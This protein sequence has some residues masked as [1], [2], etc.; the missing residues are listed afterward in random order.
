MAVLRNLF[1]LLL[2][3]AAWAHR[4][5]QQDLEPALVADDE[6]AA[7]GGDSCGMKMLQARASKDV[8]AR[9]PDADNSTS[10]SSTMPE[11]MPMDA[12]QVEGD[13]PL[14]EEEGAPRS[15]VQS[16]AT[17]TGAYHANGTQNPC[18]GVNIDCWVDAECCSARCS[19][20]RR[21]RPV[22]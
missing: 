3:A 14:A 15:F 12:A 10:N 2:V 16:S 11:S 21:C 18:K 7:D 22:R 8:K 4:P 1:A 19:L 17:Y 9:S 5:A 6:C 20:T 13:A